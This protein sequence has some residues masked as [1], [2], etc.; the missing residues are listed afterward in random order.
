MTAV[1][2][3]IDLQYLTDLLKNGLK[4]DDDK[5]DQLHQSAYEMAYDVIPEMFIP[6]NM[7]FVNASINN[8]PIK[9]MFD[10][11]AS[12]SIISTKTV[13]YLDMENF[14]DPR[15]SCIHQGIGTELSP[16][17]LWFVELNIDS[18]M[19]PVKLS[20]TNTDFGDFDMI[21]GIDFMRSYKAN[22]NFTS[23]MITLN[24]KY[25]IHF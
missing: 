14:V 21:L 23:N 3:Q 9:I 2:T 25:N 11:G 10:T 5:N 16:G 4:M 13:K 12:T 19:F 20:V 22:I 7:I 1:S 15:G 24:G 17:M 6:V 18:N 8:K